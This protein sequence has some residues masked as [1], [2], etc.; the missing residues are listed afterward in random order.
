MPAP[1]IETGRLL[2]RV[3]QDSDFEGYAELFGD[4]ESVR[5]IGGVLDRGAAWRRFLQM[6]GAWS[7]QGFGMFSIVEKSSGAW[8][9]QAGPWFPRGHNG[10]EVGW[11][12]L[13]SAWG[14]GYATEAARA[15]IDWTFKHLDWHEVIHNIMPGNAASIALAERLGSRPRGPG[16]LA[17]PFHNVDIG[18]WGQ[19][20]AEWIARGKHPE[21]SA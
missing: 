4:E 12:L 2:L 5:Y 17:P 11:I 9:G 21:T 1:C 20:R 15:A 18:V 14:R 3:P 19:T 6:P 13:R 7:I 10:T 16:Q 8:I